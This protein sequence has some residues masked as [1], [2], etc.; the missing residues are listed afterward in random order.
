MAGCFYFPTF[1]LNSV[2]GLWVL[3][4]H[5]VRVPFLL[6]IFTAGPCSTLI[7]EESFWGHTW[8]SGNRPV[9]WTAV[10]VWT[11]MFTITGGDFWYY[12]EANICFKINGML[13]SEFSFYIRIFKISS[14]WRLKKINKMRKKFCVFAEVLPPCC[15]SSAWVSFMTHTVLIFILKF[16]TQEQKTETSLC[17]MYI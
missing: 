7:S 14:D 5:A 12:Q 16:S 9:S 13:D 11:M 15:M 10:I 3:I 17:H 6:H 4:N 1:R 2:M 8:L